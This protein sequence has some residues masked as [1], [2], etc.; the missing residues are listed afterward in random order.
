[1]YRELTTERVDYI[2]SIMIKVADCKE[3]SDITSILKESDLSTE[4][5]M[6]CAC[7]ASTAN[8]RMIEL[9]EEELSIAENHIFHS[10]V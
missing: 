3:V 2:K 8:R 1:M 7:A 4:E 10:S 6:W 5:A 9:L